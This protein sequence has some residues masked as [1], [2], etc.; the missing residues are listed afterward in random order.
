M[1]MKIIRALVN[2]EE[3]Y[4]VQKPD[5][6]ILIS[7]P[8]CGEIKY[9]EDYHGDYKL[10][11][12]CT[13]SK[14]VAVGVNYKDHALEMGD[15]LPAEPLIFLKPNTCVIGPKDIIVYPPLSKRVDY[16]AEFAI[17]IKKKAKNITLEN[18]KDYILGYTCL[19]DVTARD[20]QKSDG[21]WT[22]G[23]GFDTFAPIGP[24][25]QTD[26]CPDDL[27]V[28]SRLNGK[29]CQSSS[30]CQLIFDPLYLVS[31]ISTAMT[32]L[33]GDVITTGTPGGIG[34]MKIGD[35]IEVEVEG[36]GILENTVGRSDGL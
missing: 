22:R 5:K 3:K 28:E 35:I 25:I 2:G 24:C 23:K 34:P 15:E 20:I 21:Q 14:I 7:N 29:V 32:L 31:Y 33:P 27:K 12:P 30:T 18:A 16:E 19:N 8:F 10:L 1:S 17:V 4:C 36:I 9:L 11:A 6:L 26:L 13:P